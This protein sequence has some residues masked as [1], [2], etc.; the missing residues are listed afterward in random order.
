MI[1]T[2]RKRDAPSGTDRDQSTRN[3]LRAASA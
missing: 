2:P 3:Q 1:A